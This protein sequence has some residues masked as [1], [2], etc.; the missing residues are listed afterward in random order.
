MSIRI[1]VSIVLLASPLPAYAQE[2]TL[3]QLQAVDGK[4]DKLRA[5]VKTYVDYQT[6]ARAPLLIPLPK[7]AN[8]GAAG[9][10]VCQQVGFN[11]SYGYLIPTLP[12]QAPQGYLV[13]Y[14]R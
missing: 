4:V 10:K 9:L 8:N 2:V 7:E 13:C 5:D 12:G 3:A 14:M 11:A 6:R 1:L